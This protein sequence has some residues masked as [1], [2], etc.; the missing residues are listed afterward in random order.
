MYRSP[1][2]HCAPLLRSCIEIAHQKNR[3]VWCPFAVAIEGIDSF[4]DQFGAIQFRLIITAPPC[5][6]V[7]VEHVKLLVVV[8]MAPVILR[9]ETFFSGSRPV[10]KGETGPGYHAR[11][12]FRF[13]AQNLRRFRQLKTSHLAQA[14]LVPSEEDSHMFIVVTALVA[15]PMMT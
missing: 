14:K 2:R 12:N 3:P 1:K 10:D 8:P 4:Q 13:T 6:K 9:I 11:I 15:F 7:C 5:E